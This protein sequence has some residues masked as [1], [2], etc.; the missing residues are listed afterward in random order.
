MQWNGV[1][2]RARELRRAVSGVCVWWC[3]RHCPRR[4]RAR[5]RPLAFHLR[6]EGRRRRALE[7]CCYGAYRKSIG[8]SMP[9]RD[10]ALKAILPARFRPGRPR[11]RASGPRRNCVSPAFMTLMR[12]FALLTL[13]PFAR[14]LRAFGPSRA[15]LSPAAGRALRGHV[16]DSPGEF[17]PDSAVSRSSGY[18]CKNGSQ[19]VLSYLGN[20]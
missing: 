7:G 4:R 16:M 15:P 10:T 2:S 17:I 6:P 11:R 3:R 8:I 12:L 5:A 18:R 1:E 13:Y 9:R 19:V 14:L 20:G